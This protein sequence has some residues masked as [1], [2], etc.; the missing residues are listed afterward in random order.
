MWTGESKLFAVVSE[1][2]GEWNPSDDLTTRHV[3]FLVELESRGVTFMS[4]PLGVD[5]SGW[6]GSGLTVIRA[7]S[8]NDAREIMAVEPYSV[9]GVRI[10]TIRPWYVT[11]GAMGIGVRLS[12]PNTNLT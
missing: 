4:G 12:D 3:A 10:Q 1:P 11:S 9:S 5:A 2:V 8:L 6:H 7:E